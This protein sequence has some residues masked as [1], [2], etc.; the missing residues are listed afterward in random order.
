[1]ALA[2]PTVV[3]IN[4]EGGSE[5]SPRL[6]AFFR[7]RYYDNIFRAESPDDGRSWSIPRPTILPNNNKAVQALTLRSGAVAIVFDNNRGEWK[8]ERN[9]ICPEGTMQPLS[10]A[11]SLDEGHTWPYVR[12]LQTEFD[13]RL[14]FTYPSIVQTP[15]GD[16]HISYTWSSLR[17]RTAIRYVRITEQWIKE[18]YPW[19]FTRGVYQPHQNHAIKGSLPL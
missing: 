14:E 13:K 12:D 15:N 8:C 3:R 17:R 1:M 19:G 4:D 6:V 2:Q 10:V 16:I 18:P 9:N 11:L 5:W 7:S